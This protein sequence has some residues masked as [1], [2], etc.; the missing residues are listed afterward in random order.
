MYDGKTMPKIADL[1][2]PTVNPEKF[3]VINIRAKTFCV[4]RFLSR[5]T[6]DENFQ[7]RKLITLYIDYSK[8]KYL[9]CSYDISF[10]L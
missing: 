5:Q 4:I 1:K 8:P 10:P 7:H 3:V 2:V 9:N 6:I